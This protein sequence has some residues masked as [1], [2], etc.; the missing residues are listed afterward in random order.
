M[1]NPDKKKHAPKRTPAQREADLRQFADLARQGKTH[2]ECVEWIRLN[3][4]YRISR[5]QVTYDFRELVARW[6][7]E[8]KVCLDERMAKQLADIDAQSAAA[9]KAWNDSIGEVTEVQQEQIE[10]EAGK[11]KGR[12]VVKKY[13]SHGDPRYLQMAMNCV[14]ARNRLLG[15]TRQKFELSGPDGGPMEVSSGTADFDMEH[16][17]AFLKR[18]YEKRHDSKPASDGKG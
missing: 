15:L 13:K 17:D 11:P 3:R 14:E 8:S 10:G 12:A 16:I 7:A 1:P 6:Q 2:K 4:P 9:W 5:E 18:H